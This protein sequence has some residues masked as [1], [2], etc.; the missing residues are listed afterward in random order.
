MTNTENFHTGQVKWFN[1]K[2]GY[3]FVTNLE[4]REDVFV[5]HSGLTVGDDVYR[6]LHQGEYI[7]YR[8]SVDTKGKKCASE[9]RGIRGGLLMCEV[10]SQSN[11][12]EGVAPAG[13]LVE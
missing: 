12:H 7:E 4:T 8:E 2:K 9:V 11:H 3:G 5:H 1:N 13:E 10:V 6:A